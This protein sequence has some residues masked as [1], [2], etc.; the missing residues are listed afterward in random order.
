M[1]HKF[2]HSLESTARP[3]E[4]GRVTLGLALTKGVSRYDVYVDEET[5]EVLLRPFTELPAKEAWL[6]EN[7]IAKDLVKKGLNAAK[8][9]KFSKLEFKSSNWIDKVKDDE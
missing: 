8:N 6:Y 4:R 2:K 5:G 9:K 3:D 7:K 1:A